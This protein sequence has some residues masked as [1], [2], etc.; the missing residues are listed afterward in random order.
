MNQV[1]IQQQVEAFEIRGE[2]FYTEALHNTARAMV[3]QSLDVQPGQNIL[4]W[5]DQTGLPLIKELYTACQAKGATVTFFERDLDEDARIIPTL[6]PPEIQEYFSQQKQLVD[7]A[8]G[9]LIVRGP[10]N[11]EA[12]KDVPKE[13]LAAYSAGYNEVHERRSKDL[14]DGGVNWCLFLWP[15]EYEAQKEKL[16]H[17]V[18]VHEYFE[19][20]NQPWRLIKEAQTKLKDILD[21]GKELV[22]VANADDPDPEK[23]T[24]LTMDIDGMTFCNSTIDKNYPGSEVFSAPVM[25]SVN[26]QLFAEGEYVY[27]NFLMK[28]IFLRFENGK[29]VEATAREG[30][31]G[32][33]HILSQGE[34]ARYLG[35]VA[36]GTNRGLQRR[37]FNDLL[38]EK[39]GG[40]FHVA[41]GHCYEYTEYG[42]EQVHVNNGNTS[43]RTPNHWDL[44]I[45]MHKN[46]NVIVDGVVIQENGVFI[47]PDLAILNPVFR[48][49][50]NPLVDDVD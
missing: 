50:R 43:D 23:R 11:P 13:L 17:E 10:E 7:A 36:L 29:I 9:I 5:F 16:P 26:G 34:G 35:E 47:D 41:L 45:L 8:D 19:A 28:D 37:F 20:C 3:E 38:N 15:T 48:Q 2:S 4:L 1:E 6:S 24:R 14:K 44:T 33:Q 40:S 32:L 42:G 49:P 22:L 18:Y 27:D 12:M 21:H 39:V 31:E 46:G 30:N 25:T